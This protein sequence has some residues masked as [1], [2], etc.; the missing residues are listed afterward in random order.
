MIQDSQRR[1]TE[2]LENDITSHTIVLGQLARPN[3]NT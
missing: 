2:T 1:A 3:E